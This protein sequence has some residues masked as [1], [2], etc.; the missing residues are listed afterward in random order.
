MEQSADQAR[1]WFK[2]KVLR[3]EGVERTGQCGGVP[4]ASSDAHTHLVQEPVFEL[5]GERARHKGGEYTIKCARR[6]PQY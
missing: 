2:G 3:G 6:I 5:R 1:E 4:F